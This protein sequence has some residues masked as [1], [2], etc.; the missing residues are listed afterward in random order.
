MV[1]S[2]VLGAF[3]GVILTAHVASA[4]P[5]SGD[6]YLLPAFAAVFVGAT[7][8]KAKRFNA[9]GTLIAVYMLGTGQYGLV[10]AGA[11][12]WTPNLFQGV[13][14]IAAIGLTHLGSSR[15]A[16]NQSFFRLKKL[17]KFRLSISSGKKSVQISTVSEVHNREGSRI[18]HD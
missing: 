6:T 7:Q 18:A 17:T 11:P 8:F 3:A 9:L 4:S 1:L 12:T 15:Q 10:I 5:N 16:D 13:A 14:L 2:G